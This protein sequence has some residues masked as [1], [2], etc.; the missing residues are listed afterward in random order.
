MYYKL[1]VFVKNTKNGKST[2]LTEPFSMSSLR[3]IGVKDTDENILY[4]P[5]IGE[6]LL[7]ASEV[8]GWCQRKQEELI[9]YYYQRMFLRS[10]CKKAEYYIDTGCMDNSLLNDGNPKTH[11]AAIKHMYEEIPDEFR[12]EITWEYILDL[13][14]QIRFNVKEW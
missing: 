9:P 13:E 6:S 14:R 11:I 2:E 12:G 8:I 10:L 4:V 1:A 3:K 7:Y 5:Q